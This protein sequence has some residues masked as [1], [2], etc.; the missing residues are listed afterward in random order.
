MC[1]EVPKYYSRT[2]CMKL[3]VCTYMCKP[4]LVFMVLLHVIHMYSRTW[5]RSGS[6]SLTG[7][8]DVSVSRGWSL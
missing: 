3:N 7:L 6:C 2:V 8:F 1:V 5:L 4:L